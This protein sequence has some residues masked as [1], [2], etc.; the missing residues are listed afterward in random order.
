MFFSAGAISVFI[1]IVCFVD[2]ELAW[3]LYE[4]DNQMWGQQ[5]EQ[6]KDWRGRVRYMGV[7]LLILGTMAFVAGMEAL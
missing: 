4:L 6:P 5:I 1:G 7:I 2:T 3:R